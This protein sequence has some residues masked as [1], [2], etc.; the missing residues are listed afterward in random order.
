MSNLFVLV[1]NDLGDDMFIN[2]G[3]IAYIHIPSR[4]VCLDCV[5][6]KGDGLVSLSEKSLEKLLN[7]IS[8]R[9]F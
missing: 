7:S 3:K 4:T 2:V 9:L 6:E 5:D 8:A 1:E